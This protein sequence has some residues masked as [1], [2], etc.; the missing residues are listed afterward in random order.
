MTLDAGVLADS[1]PAILRGLGVTIAIWLMGVALAAVLGFLVALGRRYGPLPLGLALRAYVEVLRGTPFLVQVFLLYFGGP[2]IGLSLEP[3]P[4][5]L[6]ALS[7]YGSAYFAEVVRAGFEA[8]PR[9]HVEAAECVGL[10]RAQI[11]RRILIPE[12]AVLVMPPAVN[13]AIALLKETAILS[14][15]SVPELTLV[16]TALG[17]QNYAFIESLLFLAVGYWGL[18]EISS[19]LGRAAETRLARYG[20][21]A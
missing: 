1:L 18:V 6:L 5:G 14:V 2:F 15:I 19:R 20:F 7:L 17:S 8:V 9:G 16:A 13:L 3:V 11:V 10:S 21:A 4:A 12:M